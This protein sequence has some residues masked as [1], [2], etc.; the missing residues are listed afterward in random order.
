MK[1]GT[2]Y[3]HKQPK[4]RLKHLL[5]ET[6]LGKMQRLLVTL[7]SGSLLNEQSKLRKMKLSGNK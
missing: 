2:D 5:T 4:M 3:A 7:L 1:C 6:G